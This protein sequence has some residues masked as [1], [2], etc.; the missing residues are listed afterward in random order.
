M[1]PWASMRGGLFDRR[2][3]PAFTQPIET[4]HWCPAYNHLSIFARFR[5]DAYFRLLRYASPKGRAKPCW[6][7]ARPEAVGSLVGQLGQITAGQR[8]RH[9]GRRGQMRAALP[10][11]TGS[12]ASP[13]I[14]RD[15]DEAALTARIARPV[16][17]GVDVIFEICRAGSILD[18]GL[19]NLNSMRASGLCG[20]NQRYNTAPRGIRN[21]WQL[22]RQNAPH[23]PGR[24]WPIMS[25]VTGEGCRPDGSLAAQVAA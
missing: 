5:D 3:G 25:T 17:H 13:L 16:P 4:R 8:G 18:A 15:K 6:S 7:A 19:M 21:L 24:W 12:T 22:N 1:G 10:R 11:N 23:I 9:R 2:F 20:L 14:Y